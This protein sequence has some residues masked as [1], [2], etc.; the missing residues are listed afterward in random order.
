MNMLLAITLQATL[1]AAIVFAVTKLAG[2]WIPPA[3]WPELDRAEG[4]IH[5]TQVTV[6]N[7]DPQ[8]LIMPAELGLPDR[9][10]APRHAPGNRGFVDKT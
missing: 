3:W 5:V 7:A 4:V 6:D 8:R 1:L 2:R 10:A 9:D